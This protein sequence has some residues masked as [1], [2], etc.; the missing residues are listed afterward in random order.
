MRSG[1]AAA[2]GVS[3]FTH[4]ALV[5][6]YST[7]S[8]RKSETGIRKLTTPSAA[9]ADAHPSKTRPRSA[10]PGFRLVEEVSGP[11]FTQLGRFRRAAPL[12]LGISAMTNCTRLW[13]AA[14]LVA[15]LAAGACGQ[16]GPAATNSG[17]DSVRGDN[18]IG[19]DAAVRNTLGR[20]AY[21]KDAD[22]NLIAT[23]TYK[24]RDDLPGQTRPSS[25]YAKMS[26]FEKLKTLYD[27]SSKDKAG[28]GTLLSRMGSAFIGADGR[29][30]NVNLGKAP[31]AQGG[32]AK[33][34]SP[35][36]MLIEM[37]ERGY[38]KA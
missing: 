18:S 23:D 19:Y 4:C 38:G 1:W 8:I 3:H 5:G 31:F 24:F 26:T 10:C 6:D 22:G 32:V 15:T 28:V 21:N 35:E 17:D 7:K 12:L 2:F 36:E 14:F 37:M 20:F 34:P 9:V 33:Y 11:V 13:L 27:D 29:P 16:N 30:V 25:D